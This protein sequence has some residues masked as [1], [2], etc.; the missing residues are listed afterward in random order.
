MVPIAGFELNES[1]PVR[2]GPGMVIPNSDD[3]NIMRLAGG[4]SLKRFPFKK[5]WVPPP[6]EAY[7]IPVGSSELKTVPFG[8]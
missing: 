5:M 4:L 3:L 6:K 2:T 7:G 8:Y 1:S